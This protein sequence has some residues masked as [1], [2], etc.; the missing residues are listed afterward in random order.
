MTIKAIA[1]GQ[2]IAEV[3]G[4]GSPLTV[5]LHGWGRDRRDVVGLADGLVGTVAAFDLPGFGSASAPPDVWGAREYARVVGDAIDDMRRVAHAR[6]DE[7]VVFGHSFGGRVAICLAATTH[8]RG[9]VLSGV[10]LLRLGPRP[11]PSLA[12]RLARGMNRLRLLSDSR[13]EQVRQKRGSAD[14][15]AA[16]GVMRGVLVRTVGESYEDELRRVRCSV[17]LVWGQLDS[18]ASVAVAQQATTYLGAPFELVVIDGADHDVH[19]SHPE[20]VRRA[21]LDLSDAKG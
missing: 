15:R 13:M 9:I 4:E 2:V 20:A 21:I 1:G 3:S 12:F 14:Y 8:V 18:A 11:K 6:S 17:R 10:P 5:L 7:V 19:R 16:S